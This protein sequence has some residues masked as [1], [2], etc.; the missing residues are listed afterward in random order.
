MKFRIAFVLTSC[1]TTSAFAQS[2][3]DKAN[4]FLNSLPSDLRA[5]CQFAMNEPD[6]YDFNFV[7]AKRKGPTFHDFNEQQKKL[8][9]DLLRASLS[10]QGFTKS[11]EIMELEKVLIAVEKRSAEDHYRDPLNY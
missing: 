7:P 6:R 9:L 11:A 8:A 1:L 10:E 4:I 3:A 2:V 5:S